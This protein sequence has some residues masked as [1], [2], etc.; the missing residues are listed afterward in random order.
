MEALCHNN[1]LGD[2]PLESVRAEH[3][4]RAEHGQSVTSVLPEVVIVG[5]RLE[6]REER[7]DVT[8]RVRLPQRL[9]QRLHEVA[10]PDRVLL[11][12]RMMPMRRLIEREARRRMRLQE[13]G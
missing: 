7:L 10:K 13:H 2:R 9:L 11:V 8:R 3:T 5:Q 12:V 6:R 4:R 1:Q